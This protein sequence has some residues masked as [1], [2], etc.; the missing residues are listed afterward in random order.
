MLA[1]SLAVSDQHR[2]VMGEQAARI[3]GE[4]MAAQRIQMGLLPDPASVFANEKRFVVAATLEPA[5]RVGGD[6]YDCFMID[7]NRL[8]ITVADVSGKGTQPA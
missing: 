8:F 3:G 1:A 2:R 7:K 4:L 5:R 6:F